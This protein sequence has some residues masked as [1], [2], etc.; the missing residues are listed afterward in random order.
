MIGKLGGNRTHQRPF[1]GVAVATGAEHHDEFS[2]C[3]GP[4]RLQRLCQRIRLVGII[5]KDRRSVALS[6]TLQPSPRAFEM[7]QRLECRDRIA[8]GA[9]R[10]AC[11]NDRVLDL[12][13]ADQ[14]QANGI[15]PAQVTELQ[16][17]GES[18]DTGCND[19][20]ALAC[21][22]A[23][24]SDADQSQFPLA[25]GVNHLLRAVVIGADDRRAVFDNQLAKQ[26]QFG[27]KV[28]RD[29]GW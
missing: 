27:S 22:V 10:K 28:M 24:A 2:L 5:D 8:A 25:C 3:I 23:A 14:R 12:E 17:L 6:D 18:I 19:S 26:T 20:D 15:Y 9:D 16:A 4:Q 7:F 1:A 21:A 13:L 11:G 29:V